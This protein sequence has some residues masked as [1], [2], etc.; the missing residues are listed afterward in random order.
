MASKIPYCL[1]DITV[2]ALTGS[3]NCASGWVSAPYVMP[4]PSLNALN[5]N[6]AVLNDFN[7]TQVAEIVIF[8]LVIFL[9][10]FTAGVVI[11]NLRR[12]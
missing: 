4:D 6:L 1:T 5:T 3:L 9:I 7:L 10:G 2:D 8:C 11:R 12:L